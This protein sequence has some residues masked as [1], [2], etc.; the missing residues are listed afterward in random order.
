MKNYEEEIASLIRVQ[1]DSENGEVLLVFRITSEKF[2]KNFIELWKSDV[3]LS[4]VKKEN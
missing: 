2:K 4:L 3:E 1:T